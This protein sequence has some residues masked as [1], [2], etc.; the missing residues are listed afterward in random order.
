MVSQRD[1]QQNG[2]IAHTASQHS[3]SLQ[4]GV[5]CERQQL[6]AC[7]LPHAR[8]WHT[9]AAYSTQDWS[10]PKVQH[11]GSTAHTVLQHT[12]SVQ[13]GVGCGMK[14]LPASGSPQEMHS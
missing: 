11:D 1:R 7:E 5:G 3:G 4:N 2:S 6:A 12:P 10:H 9:S 13:Y 8:S 14:Q